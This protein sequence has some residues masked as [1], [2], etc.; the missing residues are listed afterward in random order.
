M[1]NTL[2]KKLK[3]ITFL[4]SISLKIKFVTFYAKTLFI[5]DKSRKNDISKKK[6]L[7][8]YNNIKSLFIYTVLKCLLWTDMGVGLINKKKRVCFFKLLYKIQSNIE[9]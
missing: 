2:N 5:Q 7:Y 3:L 6:N 4:I 8:I 1:I 9:I